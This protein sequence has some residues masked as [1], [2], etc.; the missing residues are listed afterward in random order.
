RVRALAQQQH[1]GRT[2]GRAEPR[3][4]PA[5]DPEHRDERD[6]AE[7]DAE[8]AHEPRRGPAEHVP[9]GV[10]DRDLHA[11]DLS[12][13]TTS[14]RGEWRAGPAVLTAATS[15]SLPTAVSAT[16]RVTTSPGTKRPRSNSAML[17]SSSAPP[18]P[19]ARPRP[20][21]TSDS[22][23]TSHSTSPSVKPSVLSTAT[24]A[25]RSRADIAIV[26][27]ATSRIANTTAVPIALRKK[28]MLP[29]I[30]TKARLN[31]FS[32]CERVGDAEFS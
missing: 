3:A 16:E 15:S 19:R 11:T 23:T 22:A 9:D 6:V 8:P 18:S 20:E 14:R 12:A 25:K 21:M 30:P 1:V 5:R 32:V 2:A 26:L 27:A 4:S 29:Y 10:D 31:A 13:W 17:N 7:G 28:P 24:S